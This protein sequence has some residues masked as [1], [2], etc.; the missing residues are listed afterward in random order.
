MHSRLQ[1]KENPFFPRRCSRGSV[2]I[3][4]V[5]DMKNSRAAGRGNETSRAGGVCARFPHANRPRVASFRESRKIGRFPPPM[6]DIFRRFRAAGTD[7]YTP[8]YLFIHLDSS[9]S[10]RDLR[11]FREKCTAT[12][13]ARLENYP[14][15]RPTRDCI[16]RRF[17]RLLPYGGI[18][19]RIERNGA[20]CDFS[21][22]MYCFLVTF[23]ECET[24]F[25]LVEE[26]GK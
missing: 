23:L 1:R 22:S 3:A 2:I 8:M 16:Y 21:Y 26:G 7:A 10:T 5:R 19:I 15:L 17:V 18:G 14:R 9:F 20:T 6:E 13:R 11:L 12:Y 4:L 24:F 25:S